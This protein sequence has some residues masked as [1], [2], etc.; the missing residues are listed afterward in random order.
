MDEIAAARGKSSAQVAIN[1]C[2]CKGAVPIPG[3][4]SLSQARDS[5]GA[6]GWRLSRAEVD[7]LDLEAKGAGQ[8]LVQNI[9]QTS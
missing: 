6:M 7:A 8:E 9:F 5:L 2:M 3:A 4:K 1:W